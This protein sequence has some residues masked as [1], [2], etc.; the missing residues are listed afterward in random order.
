MGV[1][2]TI[3]VKGSW[4]PPVFQFL[5]FPKVL[6]GAPPNGAVEKTTLGWGAPQNTLEPFLGGGIPP[7]GIKRGV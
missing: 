3:G 6:K 7:L 5:R 2:W 1:S 4:G